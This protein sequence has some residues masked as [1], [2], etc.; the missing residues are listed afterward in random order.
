[1]KVTRT[2]HAALAVAGVAHDRRGGVVLLA[3]PGGN[4][5]ELQRDTR[6]AG[7]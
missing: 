2:S 1:M 6:L 7:A 4:T 5:I 3:D